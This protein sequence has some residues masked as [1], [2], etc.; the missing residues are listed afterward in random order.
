MEMENRERENIIKELLSTEEKYLA[1]LNVMINVYK[2]PLEQSK[3]LPESNIKTIFMNVN[4]LMNVS[5]Q[6]VK[7]LNDYYAEYKKNTGFYSGGH[8]IGKIFLKVAPFFATYT[9]YCNKYDISASLIRTLKKDNEKFTEFLTK[10]ERPHK[11]KGGL[12][13]VSYLIMPVQRV[14]RYE[15]LLRE[16]LK[17]SDPSLDDY[18]NL[19]KAIEKVKTTTA[20]MNEKLKVFDN[21]KKLVIIQQRLD[22][23]RIFQESLLAN[24]TITTSASSSRRQG[25]FMGLITPRG[26]MTMNKSQPRSFRNSTQLSPP[27]SQKSLERKSPSPPPLNRTRKSFRESLSLGKYFTHSEN[28]R[29]RSSL[30]GKKIEVDDSISD[31]I[32]EEKEEKFNIIEPHRTFVHEGI[33]KVFTKEEELCVELTESEKRKAK[34]NT[35]LFSD[36]ILFCIDGPTPNS[37]IYQSQQMLNTPESI[38]WCREISNEMF[39]LVTHDITYT[40]I[41]NNFKEKEVWMNKIKE[42]VDAIVT[43]GTLNYDS[44]G[45][46]EAL[47]APLISLPSNTLNEPIEEKKLIKRKSSEKLKRVHVRTGNRISVNDCTT[48]TMEQ[49]TLN[50]I[51]KSS[52]EVFQKIKEE[53]KNKNTIPIGIEISVQKENENE[54]IFSQTTSPNVNSK[55][56]NETII[57][58]SSPKISENEITINIET[59]KK[60]ENE[61][62]NEKEMKLSIQEKENMKEINNDKKPKLE[63]NLSKVNETKEQN[64]KKTGRSRNYSLT[65]RLAGKAITSQRGDKNVK[66]E[67]EK[68]DENSGC[69][70]C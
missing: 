65:A 11:Q 41:A 12:P 29:R 13:L 5:G 35:L 2:K 22:A 61:N 67:E 10:L 52:L 68:K 69:I 40:F 30:F 48:L 43:K 54:I 57:I 47:Y 50:P 20:N 8:S 46:A 4:I 18:E 19:E 27:L 14:P 21:K 49:P 33:L 28:G 32:E 66:Q 15:L 25:S 45:K 36:M 51:A 53:S 16:L 60:N 7:Q 42:V 31:D 55:E 62:K 44:I 1:D 64:V 37:L 17:A 38:P 3:I 63:L 26:S 23:P 70:I 39:Q 9:E 24:A 56:K 6:L 59:P 34:R 58:E